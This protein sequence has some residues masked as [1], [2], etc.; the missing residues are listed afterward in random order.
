[1]IRI[2]TN[3][4]YTGVLIQGRRT[5]PNYKVK[6]VIIKDKS[7]W[8][9]IEN[10]HEAIIPAQGVPISAAADAGGGPSGHQAPIRYILCP[11]VSSAGLAAHWQS[12]NPS[13]ITGKNM[14][15]TPVPQRK[16][17]EDVRGGT[18]RSES[19]KRLSLLHF[20]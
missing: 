6:K 9:R 7:E 8:S 15:T 4:L 19:W 12:G 18:F 10:A 3:E 20:I 2:L 14:P 13:L 1:M 11:G 16:K 17:R 5:T